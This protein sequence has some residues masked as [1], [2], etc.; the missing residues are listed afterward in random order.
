M[1]VA[2]HGL[3]VLFPQTPE[4]LLNLVRGDA[5]AYGRIRFDI[6][7]QS[8]AHL[9]GF[10]VLGVVFISVICLLQGV[11]TN[12]PQFSILDDRIVKFGAAG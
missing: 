2:E 9:G 8:V 6:G 5:V 1:D 12:D 3:G 7:G 11:K 4:G 10:S